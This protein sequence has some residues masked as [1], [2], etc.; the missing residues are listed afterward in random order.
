MTLAKSTLHPVLQIAVNRA[1]WLATLRDPES[2]AHVGELE[3]GGEPRARCCLGHACHALGAQR[4]EVER[5]RYAPPRITYDG[6]SGQLPPSIAERLDISRNGAF[7]N[8]VALGDEHYGCLVT[9][10]DRYRPTPR[11]MASIIEREMRAGNFVTFDTADMRNFND[12]ADNQTEEDAL[13]EI[14]P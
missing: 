5:A 13:P 14:E 8:P 2:L 11:Q 9:V 3:S 1:L 4:N 12:M 7:V 6:F 10:N